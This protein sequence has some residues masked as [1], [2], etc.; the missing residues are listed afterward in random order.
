[1]NES[2]VAY[3]VEDD[4]D[5]SRSLAAMLS[6][7]GF[8]THSFATGEEWLAFDPRLV[9]AVVILDLNLGSGIGGLEVLRR[10]KARDVMPPVVVISAFGNIP[11]AVDAM[12]LGAATFLEKP[13]S[14]EKLLEV[15]ETSLLGFEDRVSILHEINDTERLLKQLGDRER[16]ILRLVSEG[17][18]TKWI[19]SQLILGMRTVEAARSEI[20]KHFG[21]GTWQEVIGRVNRYLGHRCLSL[22]AIYPT[23]SLR[24][25]LQERGSPD[26][27]SDR[28]P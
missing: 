10:M 23:S 2:V 21:V 6:A 3:I 26:E 15:V 1:M 28:L 14:S 12:H 27:I 17:F 13:F 16:L 24:A 5:A 20:V 7:C 11:S 8:E 4:E 18:P 9:R 25:G 19:A 22:A